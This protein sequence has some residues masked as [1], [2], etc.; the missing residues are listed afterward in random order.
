MSLREY[1]RTFGEIKLGRNPM[2]GYNFNKKSINEYEVW[3]KGARD[4]WCEYRIVEYNDGT[5]TK[6]TLRSPITEKEY[7]KRNLKGTV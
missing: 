3:L 2:A 1:M 7:F 6:A 4:M 5:A